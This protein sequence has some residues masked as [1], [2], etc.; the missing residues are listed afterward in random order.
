[1]NR[2]LA[3]L[4]RAL[5]HGKQ[6]EIWHLTET[7]GRLIEQNRTDDARIRQLDDGWAADRRRIAELRSL[8]NLARDLD[9]G[10]HCP[11]T[12]PEDMT[13]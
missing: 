8:N 7:I 11:D 1:V 3:A 6:R 5:I 10:I 12:V 9:A 13:P 2:L 4:G